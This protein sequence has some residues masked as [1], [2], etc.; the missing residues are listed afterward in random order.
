[1][2]ALRT[3]AWIVPIGVSNTDRVWPKGRPIPKIGGHATMRVGRAVPARGRAARRASTARR[4]SRGDGL[5]M[6][7]R[8]AAGPRHRA[9]RRR[10]PRRSPADPVS[11]QN[12][13]R[14]QVRNRRTGRSRVAASRRRPGL[15]DPRQPPP[16]TPRL[17]ATAEC[18]QGRRMHGEQ[19]VAWNCGKSRY[20]RVGRAR[21]GPMRYLNRSWEPSKRSDREAHRLLLRR[22]RGD[23]QGQGGSAAGK[24]RTPSARSST[25]RA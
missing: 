11:S 7:D 18:G 4:R 23:R 10:P 14:R 20:P 12:R 15:G 16:T 24:R 3:N 6:R 5:I 8:R 13:C 19:S 1:M 2:L 22:A 21:T 9:L 25:T 17:E